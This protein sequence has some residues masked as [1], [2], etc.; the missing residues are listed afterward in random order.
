MSG[1]MVRI[2]TALLAGSI[3]Y[4]CVGVYA[5]ITGISHSAATMGAVVALVWSLMIFPKMGRSALRDFYLT[6]LTFPVVGA[7][8]GTFFIPTNGTFSGLEAALLLPFWA[9]WPVAPL[10]LLGGLILIFAPRYAR[11]GVVAA[12]AASD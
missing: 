9:M 5:Q 8:A 12:P 4:I 3:A 7:F 6:F 10:Y 2:V 1:L 11:R